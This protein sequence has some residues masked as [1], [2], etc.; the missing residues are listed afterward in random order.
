[1]RII[2]FFF[3]FS[4]LQIQSQTSIRGTIKDSLQNP[5]SL[6]NV[7]LY[8]KLDNVL[9][10]FKQSSNLGQ[11]ELVCPDAET[12]KTVEK[13]LTAIQKIEGTHRDWF[14]HLRI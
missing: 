5:V 2:L 12:K 11:F 8:N 3:I 1:M 13:L 9:I 6:V 4:F 10:D 14:A 7:L